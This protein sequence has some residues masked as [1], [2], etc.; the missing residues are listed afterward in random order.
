[1]AAELHRR[2]PPL[3]QRGFTVFLTGLSGAGKSTIA[4]TLETK[5]LALGG[6]Q[7]SLLDGDVVR[8]HLSGELGYLR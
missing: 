5:L 1:V 3:S 8:R 4:R 6:R 2:F 7:V